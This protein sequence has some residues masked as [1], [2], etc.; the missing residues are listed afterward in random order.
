MMETARSRRDDDE[1][2]GIGASSTPKQHCG[3]AA[4]LPTPS[5]LLHGCEQHRQDH[6]SRVWFDASIHAHSCNLVDAG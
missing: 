2:I 4:L 6:L 5:E 3:A 1:G